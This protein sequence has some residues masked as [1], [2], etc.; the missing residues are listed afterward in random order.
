MVSPRRGDEDGADSRRRYIATADAATAA[1]H[2]TPDMRHF[3]KEAQDSWP[4]EEA[5][6]EDRRRPMM[7]ARAARGMDA[8]DDFAFFVL[9]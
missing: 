7:G 5:A 9:H 8:H 2:A 4:I 6:F 3:I 1:S